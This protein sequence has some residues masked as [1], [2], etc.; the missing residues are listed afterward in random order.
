MAVTPTIVEQFKRDIE[1]VVRGTLVFS[2]NYAT[3]GDVL[4]FT[5]LKTS[6]TTPKSVVI[7][8]D[9]GAWVITYNIATGKV[10]LTGASVAVG[11][12]GQHAAAAYQAS[13]TTPVTRFEAT[14]DTP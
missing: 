8:S 13:A 7:R 4:T 9:T 3:D 2:G 1:L 11:G 14:F 12:M 6:K 5:Q 10:I